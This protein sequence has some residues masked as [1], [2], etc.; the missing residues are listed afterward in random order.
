ME[1]LK[2]KQ[3]DDAEKKKEYEAQLKTNDFNAVQKLVYSKLYADGLINK[4]EY[5]T[6]LQE[7]DI[8]GKQN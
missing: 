3:R 4:Y 2:Q 6:K 1:A 5:D 8:S 7:L